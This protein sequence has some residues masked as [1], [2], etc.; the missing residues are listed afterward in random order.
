AITGDDIDDVETPIMRPKITG[1]ESSLPMRSG[2]RYEGDKEVTVESLDITRASEE[3]SGVET[4]ATSGDLSFMSGARYPVA[5]FRWTVNSGPGVLNHIIHFPDVIFKESP[6]LQ[7]CFKMFQYWRCNGMEIEVTSTSNVMQG[8]I[9]MVCWDPLGCASR[10]NI[11][12]LYSFSNLSHGLVR[13]G[14]SSK[15]IFDVDFD[16]IQERLSLSGYELGLLSFGDLLFCPMCPL[17][18]PAQTSQYVEINV[19]CKL[20]RS[21][22]IFRSVPHDFK[23]HF[24]L[25]SLEPSDKKEFLKFQA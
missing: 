18:V 11:N 12:D 1:R 13:A 16:V 10:R 4:G 22:F 5:T 20:K 14:M 7:E 19:F 15:L 25:A 8:G 24:D 6:W 17:R 21:D 3:T 2:G 23:L 9:L